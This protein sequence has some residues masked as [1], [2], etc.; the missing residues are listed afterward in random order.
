MADYAAKGSQRWLQI[1]IEEHPEVLLDV[2]REPLGLSHTDTI[3]WQSPIKATAYAEFRNGEALRKVKVQSRIKKPLNEFW[4]ARGPVWDAL[5][6]ASSG[7]P[8]F[9]EAKAN[10]PEAASPPSK[11]S[12][13][14]LKLITKSLE[15]TR[16]FYAPK[17]VAGWSGTFYQCANRLAYHYWLRELNDIDS[18]LV[19]LYFLN[20]EDVDFPRNGRHAGVSRRGELERLGTDA[21]EMAMAASSIVEDLDVVEN[22]GPRELAGLVNPFANAFLFQA[23]EEGFGDCII[24]TIAA[25]THARI[26]AVGVAETRPVLAAVLRSLVRVHEYSLHRFAPP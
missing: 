2:L 19:F 7:A 10:I 8:I 24:P 16:N 11:A 15:Q 5:G 6:I 14:S 1:A 22:V 20:A 17:A 9:V 18:H 12:E 13:E 23:A 3:D 4:P 25:S 21:T 26:E